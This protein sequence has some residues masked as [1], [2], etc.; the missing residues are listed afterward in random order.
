[1]KR[2]FNKKQIV[3]KSQEWYEIRNK[4]V[5]STDVSTILDLNKYQS[6]RELILK[7]IKN[8]ISTP[9]EAMEWGNFFE[10]IAIDIYSKINNLKVFDL[11][12]LI[13]DEHKFLGASPDGLIIN[14]S[15][16]EIKCPFSKK[17]YKEIPINYWIQT[18]IQMEVCNLNRTVLFVCAFDKKI[19]IR[20]IFFW[21][22]RL[23]KLV[24]L[25]L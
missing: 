22:K 17:V 15:L 18:Q 10:P 24:T 20:C 9:N 16:L 11:G 6:K 12:L 5:T 25:R 13:H 8:E 19:N 2:L 1:M 14:N 21:K 4:I 3:Q 23:Y 7:K